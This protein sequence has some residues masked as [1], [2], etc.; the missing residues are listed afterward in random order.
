MRAKN[1]AGDWR[2]PFDQYEWGGPYVEGGPWQS[3]WAVQQD[4]NGLIALMGGQKQFTA[5][6][7][8]LMV[9]PPRFEI[10]SY[11]NVI[12]EMTEM[13]V[14]HFGQYGHG[15][16]P[17]HHILSLFTAAGQP[18]KAQYWTRRVMDELYS[19]SGFAGDEDNGEMASWYVL[20]ALG[21][22]PLCPGRPEYV[23]GSPLFKSVT[24]HI[25]GHKDLTLEAPKNSAQNVYVQKVSVNGKAYEPLWISHQTLAAGGK[26]SFDMGPKPL[27]KDYWSTPALLPHSISNQPK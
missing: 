11:G 23:L 26:V 16:Q 2:T 4:P 21:V 3:T 7:D 22:Y 8:Q 18:W 15:N 19:P 1:A 13:S 12:H 6:L 14:T 9:E 24:L 27:V 5:K 20:N 17:V 25:P 10:G